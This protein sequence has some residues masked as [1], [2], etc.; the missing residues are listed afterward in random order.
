M[1]LLFIG[2]IVGRPGRELVRRAVKLLVRAWQVDL[3]IANGENASAGAG[4]TREHAD[5]IFRAGVHGIT[6]GNHTWDKREILT[7]IGQEPRLVRPANYLAGTPGQASILNA[8]D[9]TRVGVVNVLGRVFLSTLDDPFAAAD[10]EIQRLRDEGVRVILVDV[11]AETTSEKIA[12][13]WWLD[14]RATAVI[15]THTHVQTADERILP[16]GTACLTDAGMTGPHDGVIGVEREAVIARFRTGLPVR[17]EP[18]TGD[19]RPNGALVTAD[20]TPAARSPS[21]ASAS[22]PPTSMPSPTGNS[23]EVGP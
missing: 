20:P 21:A 17:F 2:D 22:T 6:G 14:G 13:S 5:E 3:A 16:G 7:Y 8:T 1:K 10:R 11:H 23:A 12:I 18:A 15:G 4:L 9:G 19:P